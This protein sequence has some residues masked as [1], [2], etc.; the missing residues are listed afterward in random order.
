MVDVDEPYAG[1]VVEKLTSRKGELQEM[2]PAGAGKMRL[3]FHAPSRALIGYHG[4]FLTDTR[5]TGVLNRCSRLEPYKGP[6]A[7]A[8]DRGD[9]LVASR[10]RPWP[11]PC[12]TW[13]TAGPCS[14]APARRS[15]PA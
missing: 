4:E 12:G 11:S 2:R 9:D 8:L 13:R 6:I 7:A 1:I 10:A 14:S 3:V 5:G 15:I